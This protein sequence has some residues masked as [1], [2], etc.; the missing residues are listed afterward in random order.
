MVSTSGSHLLPRSAISTLINDLFPLTTILTPN[1]PEAKSLLE[2]AGVDVP[3]PQNVDDI[4]AI[5]RHIQERGPKWVLLKGGHLP[6]TRGRLVGAS[7]SEREVIL[8]VLVGDS[9]VTLMESPYIQS[10]N[11]HGTG[12]SLAS[13]IAC[14]LASGMP[15]VKA[16][17]NA[18]LYIEA[19]I[20]TATDLGQGNGPINHFHSTY[21]LPFTPGNFI[22]YLLDRSDIQVPWKEY[23]Q[24]EFVQRMGDGTLP[25]EKFMYYLVQDYLFLVQFAR[26]NALSAYKSSSLPDIGRSVQQVVT[27]QEEIKYHIDF[28]KEYGLSEE[29]IVNEEEDQA[30]TAYTRYVLDVGMSQDYLALQIALLPCLIGYGII[31]KRLYEDPNTVRV[32]SRYW[33]WI[34]QY[35]ASEYREAMMR[36]SDLIEKFATGLSPQRVEE[37]AGI[38]VHATNMERGFWDMGLRAGDEVIIGGFRHLRSR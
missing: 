28:C 33:K 34:E 22:K 13:A 21:T 30:T 10:R 24:H 27:L 37:L 23:T 26:A 32:G 9:G 19:G 8:N 35:V 38:F 15:M 11:T 3:D 36:G 14:N 2:V 29:D 20:K 12:C 1:L 4:V 16:V 7:E 17:K 31:A 18:N 6:L 25:V 5:A